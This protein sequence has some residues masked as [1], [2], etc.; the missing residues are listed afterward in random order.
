MSLSSI[1][2]TS[3]AGAYYL[4]RVSHGGGASRSPV[5]T[6]FQ[7][8][9]VALRGDRRCPHGCPVVAAF[10]AVWGCS[11]AGFQWGSACK[12]PNLAGQTTWHGAQGIVLRSCRL[13]VRHGPSSRGTG[14]S[15]LAGGRALWL[16]HPQ[17][18]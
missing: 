5:R 14:F 17:F 1:V 15:S 18:A 9:C 12:V 13:G 7:Q 10:P 16:G 8:G 6:H 3:F 11:I 2:L 4:G